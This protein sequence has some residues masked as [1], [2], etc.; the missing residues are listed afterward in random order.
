MTQASIGFLTQNMHIAYRATLPYWADSSV[1][2]NRLG[3]LQASCPLI[4]I[5][6]RA[7]KDHEARM[8][9]E[10]GRRFLVY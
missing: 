4:E 6:A 9:G 1:A 5:P 2:R 3:P 10:N 8:T 7:E